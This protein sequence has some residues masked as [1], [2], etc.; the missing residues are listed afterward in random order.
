[1]SAIVSLTLTPMMCSRFLQRDHAGN[2]GR[3]YRIVE[4]GFDAHDRLLRRTLDFVLR[5]RFITLMVFIATCAS[6]ACCS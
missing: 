6:P 2:H 5:H 3:L 1:M 4:G